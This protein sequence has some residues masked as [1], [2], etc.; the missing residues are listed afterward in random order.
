MNFRQPY[1][2]LIA[3]KLRQ[4]PAPDADASWQQMKRL[5]DDDE[6]TRAGGRKRPPGNNGWWRIGILAI[7]FS[8]SFWLY[9]DK[10]TLPGA[11]LSKNNTAISPQASDK[12]G[13]ITNATTSNKTQ[14]ATID[15]TTTLTGSNENT[16]AANNTAISHAKAGKPVAAAAIKNSNAPVKTSVLNTVAAANSR[17]AITKDKPLYAI[18]P[19]KNNTII[20]PVNNDKTAAKNNHSLIDQS[21]V[22]GTNAFSAG[23]TNS[24]NNTHNGI[25]N[26]EDNTGTRNDFTGLSVPAKENQS[27]TG[28]YTKI[29]QGSGKGRLNNI[30]DNDQPFTPVEDKNSGTPGN[31]SLVN[32]PVAAKEKTWFE[33]LTELKIPAS[34]PYFNTSLAAGDSIEKSRD[35]NNLLNN[36]TKKSVVKAQREKAI[37]LL[38]KK[39]KKSLHL[40]LSNVFKPFSLH[41]DAEP[42]WAAG[43]ALNTGIT[44]GAQSRY[45]YNVNAKSSILTDYIPSPYL[46]YHLNNYVYLQ[47]ELNFITPQYTP[48]LLAYRQS[49]DITAQAGMSQQKSIYIQKLYYFNWPVSLHYSPVSN[50]Y[51]S[52]GIQFSS[53]QSGLAAIEE[54]QFTTA[55]GPD[56][57]SSASTTVLKFKDDSIAAKIA[58]NE[59]RWQVGAE[60]YWNRFSVG[61]RYNQSLKNAINTTVLP[62]LPPTVNRNES[63]LFFVRY[64]LFESRRKESTNQKD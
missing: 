46:Q 30:P 37:E 50:L 57:A 11:P 62:G 27:K 55:L 15:N 2:Q 51:F 61:L 17:E 44:M 7:V 28:Q 23:N 43:I 22:A 26:N 49:N 35:V 13:E 59:W 60:Y 34:S 58:P 45:N 14:T 19:A 33:R 47:T 6:D 54:K 64:N 10:K 1:E 21:E 12:T 53:F 3:D 63:L 56:H 40:N 8:A 18:L 32:Q 39:D 29:K 36:E 52:G 42:W 24:K 4:L 25:K 5:L 48:S 31:Y 16:S 20:K 38:D 41:I 9:I